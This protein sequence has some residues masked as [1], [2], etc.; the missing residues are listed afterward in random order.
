MR[1]LKDNRASVALSLRGSIAEF[2]AGDS[3]STERRATG[4]RS[5]RTC[6]TSVIER[7]DS[8][9]RQVTGGLLI[10]IDRRVDRGREIRRRDDPRPARARAISDNTAR[11]WRVIAAGQRP[12]GMHAAPRDRVSPIRPR[13]APRIT[14]SRLFQPV[15]Q[16]LT[17]RDARVQRRGRAQEEAHAMTRREIALITHHGL[18]RE[19]GGGEREQSARY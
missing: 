10:I 19:R 11:W 15:F 17:G 7:A 6:S 14:H 18:H 5:G 9:A 3:K 4:D 2:I 1:S 8:P 12:R 16:P 13:A